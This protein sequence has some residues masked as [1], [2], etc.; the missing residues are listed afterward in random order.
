MDIIT[1]IEQFSDLLYVFVPPEAI[2]FVPLILVFTWALY[3]FSFLPR[4]LAP[5]V[6][7]AL[8]LIVAFLFLDMPW[9][10]AIPCGLTL[11]GYAIAAWSGGKNILEYIKK[12]DNKKPQITE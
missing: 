5:V 2:P 8:G 11:G 12:D 6:A 10:E 1:I 7:L 9:K 4:K 3:E